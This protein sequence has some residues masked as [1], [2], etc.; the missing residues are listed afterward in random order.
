MSGSLILRQSPLDSCHTNTWSLLNGCSPSFAS[1]AAPWV[2][3]WRSLGQ[4]K[5]S[6]LSSH[7]LCACGLS[8]GTHSVHYSTG[9]SSAWH[10]TTKR[11]VSSEDFG[12]SLPSILHRRPGVIGTAWATGKCKKGLPWLPTLSSFFA[13]GFC[14]HSGL[15][16]T[17]HTATVWQNRPVT[18][19]LSFGALLLVSLCMDE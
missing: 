12:Q 10:L 3:K 9:P 7:L 5:S 2:S 6:A 8:P 13:A 14:H 16:S 17:P 11:S 19:P 18:N 15:T 1:I 4:S